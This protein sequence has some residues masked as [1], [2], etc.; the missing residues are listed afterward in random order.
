MGYGRDQRE[1][2]VIPSFVWGTI[3]GPVGTSSLEDILPERSAYGDG[4][5][6]GH[7]KPRGLGGGLPP[8]SGPLASLLG[9]YPLSEV[10]F[11]FVFFFIAGAD[12]ER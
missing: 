11:S 1:S 3:S 9:F 8:P 4:A 7:S 2:W 5:S 6:S 10:P 12:I